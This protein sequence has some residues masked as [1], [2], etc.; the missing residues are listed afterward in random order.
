MYVYI[1]N[2]KAHRFSTRGRAEDEELDAAGPGRASADAQG[3][4]V[5]LACSVRMTPRMLRTHFD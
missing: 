4:P 1:G 3:I 5:I 2:A